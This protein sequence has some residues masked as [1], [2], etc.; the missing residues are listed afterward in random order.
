MCDKATDS[1]TVAGRSYEQI[2]MPKESHM[3]YELKQKREYHIMQLVNIQKAID[4]VNIV[5]GIY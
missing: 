2:S 5:G 3:V 1:Q 4:A